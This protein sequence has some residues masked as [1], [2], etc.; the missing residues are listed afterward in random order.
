MVGSWRPSVRVAPP[1]PGCTGRPGRARHAMRPR[2][3]P[4]PLTALESSSVVAAANAAAASPGPSADGRGA[5][6]VV[7][8]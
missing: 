6:L 1:A 4:H 2:P 3:S 8:G 7:G 5:K